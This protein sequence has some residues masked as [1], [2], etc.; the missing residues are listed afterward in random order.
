VTPVPESKKFWVFD[1]GVEQYPSVFHNGSVHAGVSCTACHG[2]DDS[3]NTRA[4]AHTDGFQAIPGADSC[5]TCHSAIAGTAADGLHTTL[6][7]YA[8]ILADRGFPEESADQT[9]ALDRYDEQCTK[10]HTANSEDQT[11][12]GFCHVSV[13]DQ[14]GGGLLG[15]HAFQGTPSMENNCTAC[16]G[17][18]VKD[19]F[20][21]QNDGLLDRNAAAYPDGHPYGDTAYQLQPDVHKAA[22]MDCMSCHGGDEIHGEG[23]P[24]TNEGDRYDVAPA[25]ACTD[26]HETDAA[27]EAV[28][29][30]HGSSHTDKVDC[31]VCHAQPYKNCFG[32]HTDVTEDGVSF[33]KNNTADPTLD[34]RKA[35]SDNPGSV[36]PDALITFRA[37][38][39]P[40]FGLDAD[41]KQYSVLR[42]VPIDEDVFQYSG[43]A[44]EDGLITSALVQALPTWK[45][46]TPHTIQRSTEITSSC[47]NCHGEDYA[48]FW[49]TDPVADAL[50]WVSGD[51]ETNEEAANSELTV[52]SPI[53]Q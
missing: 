26:C 52:D 3:A 32:C 22:G 15:G 23:H 40:R 21:G 14:A 48:A 53:S 5:D 33:F 38:I 2:G 44:L 18:R 28:T 20:Y 36:H 11:A 8:S 25:P 50:G 29:T 1:G 49:L 19:E 46:A 6:D 42:H 41:A 34:A 39:N 17:S 30:M 9:T 43:G 47:N 27:F 51:D 24:A 45:Y 4:D 12:C 37:G 16:H 7:G 35:A 31:Y 13:P 10:C